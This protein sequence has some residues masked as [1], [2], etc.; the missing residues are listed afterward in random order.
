MRHTSIIYIALLLCVVNL[1]NAQITYNKLP[2]IIPSAPNAAELSKYGTLDVGL[3]TGSLNFK[4]PIYTIEGNQWS[5]PIDLQYSTSG[6]KVDQIA[7]RVGLGWILNA[8][9]V[10]TRNVN[11]K[12]DEF[13]T[14][15][16]LPA[17]W[18]NL[19]QSFMNYLEGVASNSWS[20][21]DTEPD[22]FS[23]NFNG[24]SGKFILDASG[25]VIM[26]PHNNL[27]ASFTFNN[28]SSSSIKIVT[29]DGSQ[30]FFQ[31]MEFT[32]SNSLVAG[33]TQTIASAIPTSWYLS[34]VILPNLEE[35][36]FTYQ[37][38]AYSYISSI[39]ETITQS[40]DAENQNPCP[41]LQCAIINNDETA[42]LN[43]I[44]LAGR[45][46]SKI[47]FRSFEANFEYIDRLDL[48]S[49]SSS[50]ENDEKLLS[51]I[52]FK[53]NNK[54]LKSFDFSYQYGISSNYF[55]SFYGTETSLKY[56]P[57]LQ[58][59][60][61]KNNIGGLI[62]N[63]IFTYNDING[64]PA[65]LS[66][67]QDMFG[68]FNGKLNPVLIPKPE[69]ALD[70]QRF[71]K[72]TADRSPDFLSTLKGSLTKIQYPT[73][74]TDSIAYSLNDYYTTKQVISRENT[75]LS[76][77][78]T[79]TVSPIIK[80]SNA[81]ST[82]N[83]Q[84]A[85]LTASMLIEMGSDGSSP[86]DPI[87]D[88]SRVEVIRQSD[89]AQIYSKMLKAGENIDQDFGQM[90]PGTLYI[91][92]L[93]C[94]VPNLKCSASI[95]YDVSSSSV[96]YTETI[97]GLRVSKLLSRSDN[98]SPLIVKKYYYATLS[99]LTKSSGNVGIRPLM[100]KE[101]KSYN[102][103]GCSDQTTGVLAYY[104]C[105]NMVAYSSS[106][107]NL[108]SY[109]QN[110]VY[111][112]NVTEGLGEDFDDGGIQHT[113]FVKRDGLS[114]PILGNSATLG[115]KLS[116]S[117][118]VNGLEKEQ[119]VFKKKDGAF[120][121][122]K[123][124]VSSFKTDTI[125]RIE[126]YSINKDF[127]YPLHYTPIRPEEFEGF[128]IQ[129]YKLYSGWVRKDSTIVYDYNQDGSILLSKTGY[130][131]PNV[132]HTQIGKET[133]LTS[134][135]LARE[136]NYKYPHEMVSL[137][138]DPNGIYQGMIARNMISPVVEQTIVKNG[139]TS[140]ERR[141]F[142]QP[143]SNIYVPGSVDALNTVSNTDETRIRYEAY[144]NK[145]NPLSLAQEKGA[146]I[147]YIWSYNGQYPIAEIKNADYS[148]VISALGGGAAIT[149]FSIKPSPTTA[150]INS[151]LANLRSS[152]P[153]AQIST[154]VYDPLVGLISQTDAKGQTTFYEYDEFQRLKNVK[155]QN[156]NILKN[157]IYHYKP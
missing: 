17:N 16:T 90:A 58:L 23:Y 63:H 77:P 71:W 122:L 85:H 94:Y 139:K 111:Y 146:K 145:G 87:M 93:T 73:G 6:V 89:G 127:S 80:T 101:A 110:Y 49:S 5:M 147:N 106:L 8:G 19:D 22:E 11:G 132:L 4:I 54:V 42:S 92:K 133:I 34:K 112:E 97:P 27:K 39:S 30:Y 108:Y 125:S 7:S 152:L 64:L 51:R 119:L 143:F 118:F 124:T 149:A 12:P 74:G 66:Y 153:D 156:G 114:I 86:Y 28:S 82:T 134:D 18:Q 155:D 41:S 15:S 154:F 31:D 113:Y 13:S 138:R 121:N 3:Q 44:F 78:R 65:R 55:S 117:G 32:S 10:V 38:Q 45:R 48:P 140:L 84:T 128:N 99:D 81:F 136:V 43:L 26:M 150:E 50:H 102:S 131:Y 60:A 116:N 83:G 135:G 76:V 142:I 79:N 100:L 24:Y 9:G 33:S 72:A 148:S 25:N 88:L 37:N 96:P 69:S 126:A 141:N 120:Y 46:L 137:G 29:P 67:S 14:R 104:P 98:T 47:N 36:N 68:Y 123:R 91:L 2:V 129:K 21:D 105:K 109:S 75:S 20:G 57:Y 107:T 53:N 40:I 157:N 56:R 95:A 151:F 61:Q 62:G 52:L 59:L 103:G 115:L 1:A 70:Q 35:V 144:D 130:Q